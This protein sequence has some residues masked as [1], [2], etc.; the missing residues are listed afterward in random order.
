MPPIT[1]APE[2]NIYL[3]GYTESNAGIATAG[4]HLSVRLGEIDHFLVKLNSKGI[5]QWG[6]YLGGA[7]RESTAYSTRNLD[8]DQAGNIYV[9]STT[10]STSGIATA[11][12]HQ[13][14]LAGEEDAYLV[15]FNSNGEQ[16][17]GTYFGGEKKEIFT[18]VVC[19][20]SNNI[21]ICGSTMSTS[22]IAS[23]DAIHPAFSGTGMLS[24]GDLLLARFN[25][26]GK[27]TFGSYYG[28]K[29]DE[30]GYSMA[31]DPS[32]YV[33]VGGFTNSDS[34][35][36]TP[37][38]F[39]ETYPGSYIYNGFIARFCFAPTPDLLAIAGPDTL[40]ANDKATYTVAAVTDADEYVWTLPVNWTGASKTNRIDI[41]NG[42]TGGILG[43]QVVRCEDTSEIQYMEV[44]VRPSDPAIITVDSF[45]LGTVDA[46]ASYQWLL[47][48][49]IIPG[50]TGR[51]YTV[52]E[53]GDYA[54]VTVTA[55]GCIDTSDL[56][57]VR[58]VSI[59]DLSI[60]DRIRIFPNPGHDN[61]LRIAA[62]MPV[63]AALYGIDGRLLKYSEEGKRIDVEGVK[64]GIYLIRISDR[65]G[66]L[67]KTE[68]WT[69]W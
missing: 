44:Y 36:A 26:Q 39:Q 60:R 52:T 19:Q 59:S 17:W 24:Y 29:G 40:C 47:N 35:I 7:G 6:T 2:W 43:V 5:R 41:T 13:G 33:Y 10:T 46:Y 15:K 28:G 21:Y 58:N 62:P 8:C 12:S 3:F 30:L 65:N 16:Q 54:V 50:A 22:Q 38:S 49:A 20:D 51:N 31:Y 1:P 64:P 45:N 56:Y 23:A 14:T 69:K 42:S 68:K 9:T 66:R 57:K 63:S 53:N 37:G 48:G 67:L 18:G 34:A 32:G 27:N 61:V 55:A 25:H 4:S 11:G